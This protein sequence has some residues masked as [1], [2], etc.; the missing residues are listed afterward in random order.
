M[1]ARGTVIVLAVDAALNGLVR[2]TV[3]SDDL[4]EALFFMGDPDRIDDLAALKREIR[5][6]FY[7]DEVLAAACANLRSA[8]D[9]AEKAE[10]VIWR[11]IAESEPWEQ[12]NQFL[13]QRGL[14]RITP[15]ALDSPA[16]YSYPA[17]DRA[18]QQQRLPYRLVWA[19]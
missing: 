16:R 3:T 6:D 1:D 4:K 10:R 19:E 2:R 15:V 12:L 7:S 8:V 11:G 9:A 5:G 14:P 17:V 13:E 18:V